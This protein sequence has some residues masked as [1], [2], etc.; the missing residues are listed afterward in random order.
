MTMSSIGTIALRRSNS[1]SP[2]TAFPSPIT[3]PKRVLPKLTSTT[4]FAYE[5]RP[6]SSSSFDFNSPSFSPA[7]FS[8]G[9]K[10]LKKQS[11]WASESSVATTSSATVR[12]TTFDIPTSKWNVDSERVKSPGGYDKWGGFSCDVAHTSPKGFYVRSIEEFLGEST[13]TKR[14]R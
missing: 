7:G 4:T 8:I 5:P 2:P 12:S 6:S 11:S 1:P 13:P 3:V 9:T 10:T 14:Q